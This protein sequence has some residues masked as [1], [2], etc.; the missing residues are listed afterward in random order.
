MKFSKLLLL[1]YSMKIIDAQG[2][3]NTALDYPVTELLGSFQS[4]VG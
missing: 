2:S 1:A 4:T 3:F